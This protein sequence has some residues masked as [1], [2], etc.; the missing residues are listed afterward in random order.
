MPLPRDLV[1]E[2][3]AEAGVGLPLFIEWGVAEFVFREDAEIA[4]HLAQR[5]ELIEFEPVLERRPVVLGVARIDVL[6]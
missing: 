1:G 4:D 5:R 6:D 3:A 2:P